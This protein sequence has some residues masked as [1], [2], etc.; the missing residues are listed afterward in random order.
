MVADDEDDDAQLLPGHERHLGVESGQVP[1]VIGQQV[2]PVGCRLPAHPVGGVQDFP[3]PPDLGRGIG[4]GDGRLEGG[5]EHRRG[6]DLLS[7]KLAVVHQGDEPVGH[8]LDV[9]DDRPAGGHSA[10]VLVIGDLIKIE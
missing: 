9:G 8:V 1:A 4:Q 10:D 5:F 3:V 2:A 6:Q 7:G